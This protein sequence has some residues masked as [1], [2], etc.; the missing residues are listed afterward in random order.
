MTMNLPLFL[1]M[2]SIFCA[3]VGV[4]LLHRH[5]GL[6]IESNRQ[7]GRGLEYWAYACGWVGHVEYAS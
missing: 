4:S 5:G 2:M 3:F 6:W 1:S 7:C